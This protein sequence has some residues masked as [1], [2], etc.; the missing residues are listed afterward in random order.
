[1]KASMHLMALAAVG[2]LSGWAN[3]SA[4]DA[5]GDVEQ[6]LQ[7]LAAAESFSWVAMTIE[8]TDGKDPKLAETVE[9]KWVR[10]GWS[11]L[12]RPKTKST[13]DAFMKNDRLALMTSQGWKSVDLK[14]L[15]PGG[16]KPAKD[17]RPAQDLL[18]AK[19]PLAQARVL[20]GRMNEVGRRE[21]GLYS[22]RMA[23]L[24]VPII[25]EYAATAG[26]K[27]PT[28]E[29]TEIRVNFRIN[30]GVLG[31]YELVVS[32]RNAKSKN[33]Q[34]AGRLVSMAV[35]FTEVGTTTLEV[36]DEARKL[37]E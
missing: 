11:R 10:G 9:G 31:S 37:L 19:A 30:E 12:S 21:N 35:D 29:D 33:P 18:H 14:D 4:R 22:G 13:T 7:K 28:L 17:I 32:G 2:I 1:M 3:P 27:L 25:L 8:E 34:T 24:N 20:L 23:P 36:P 5:K 26:L 15:A 6:A 16:A